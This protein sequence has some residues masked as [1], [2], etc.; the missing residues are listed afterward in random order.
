[1]ELFID[2]AVDDDADDDDVDA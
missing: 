1:F 2:V